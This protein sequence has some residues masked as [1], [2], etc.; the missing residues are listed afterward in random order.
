MLLAESQLAMGRVASL[1][2]YWKN[3]IKSIYRRDY[4]DG[5]IWLENTFYIAYARWGYALD[6]D[7]RYLALPLIPLL[8]KSR[9]PSVTL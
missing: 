1:I 7:S 8:F 2:S 9:L 5:A 3:G 4:F 6:H